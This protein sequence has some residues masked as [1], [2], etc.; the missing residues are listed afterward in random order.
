MDKLELWRSNFAFNSA[1]QEHD[2]YRDFYQSIFSHDDG[3][4]RGESQPN[5]CLEKLRSGR[6]DYC[7]AEHWIRF[8]KLERN[9]SRILFGN[10]ESSLDHD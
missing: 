5:Q 2:L 3:R 4:Q 1:N 9:R 6:F 10:Y 8:F 7:H